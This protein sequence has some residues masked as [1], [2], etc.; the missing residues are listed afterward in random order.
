MQQA[1]FKLHCAL[2]MSLIAHEF[3]VKL[4]RVHYAYKCTAIQVVYCKVLTHCMEC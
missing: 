1:S 4:R 3:P 2:I